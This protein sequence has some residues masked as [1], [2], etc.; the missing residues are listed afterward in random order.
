MKAR[1]FKRA[2]ALLELDQGKTLTS[3]SKTLLVSY[4]TVLNWKK[5]FLS[6]GLSFLE[7][8]PRS[9]RPKDIDG[10]ARAKIC[11]SL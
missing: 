4:P 3:V 10:T 5:K 8:R 7:D 6:E 2:T 9:G 1:V 11:P